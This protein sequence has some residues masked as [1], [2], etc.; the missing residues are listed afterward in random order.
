VFL[1]RLEVNFHEG[2]IVFYEEV[3]VDVQIV[4]K[5]VVAGIA[6][7]FVSRLGGIKPHKANFATPELLVSDLGGFQSRGL[8]GVGRRLCLKFSIFHFKLHYQKQ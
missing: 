5:R 3:H 6:L 7:Q 8:A 4:K 2:L 1:G